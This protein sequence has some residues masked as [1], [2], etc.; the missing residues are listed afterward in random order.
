MN[1]KNKHKVFISYYHQE[2]QSYKDKLIQLN[3]KYNLFDDC[4]VNQYE[5]EYNNLDDESIRKIIQN[6]YI[7]KSEVIILLCGKNTKKR[8]FID[9]EIAAGMTNSIDNLQK[10]F[11]IINLPTI[12]QSELYSNDLNTFYSLN[13]NDSNKKEEN[14]NFQWLPDRLMDN[15]LNN[16][17]KIDIVNYH[18]FIN[19]LAKI[20]KLIN[21]AYNNKLKNKYNNS[22]KLMKNNN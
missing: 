18:N 8:K 15:A 17:V 7:K 20:E 6:D 5:I 12:E 21:T 9:W 13:K 11:L 2:D 4:S 22:R 1:K 19:D 10:G 14:K 3:E 16:N